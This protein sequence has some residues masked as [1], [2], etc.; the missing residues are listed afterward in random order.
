MISI[1]VLV[2]DLHEVVTTEKSLLLYYLSDIRLQKNLKSKQV[3][4][5]FSLKAFYKK[6][7]NKNKNNYNEINR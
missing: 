1:A 7:K 5:V 4:Y 2:S 3:K 6:Q